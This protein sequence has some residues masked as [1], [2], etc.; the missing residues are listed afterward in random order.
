MGCLFLRKILMRVNFHVRLSSRCV[1]FMAGRPI[2]SF[3]LEEFGLLVEAWERAE[4]LADKSWDLYG[5]ICDIV[6]RPNVA[7]ETGDINLNDIV[8]DWSE[9]DSEGDVIF[10]DI[11]LENK[12]KYDDFW[13]KQ[14]TLYDSLKKRKRSNNK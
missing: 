12:Q 6:T 9:E 7:K 4:Y 11:R 3:T 8:V 14:I 2:V 1:S 13:H 10:D 5:C